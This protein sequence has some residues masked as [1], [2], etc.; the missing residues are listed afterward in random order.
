MTSKKPDLFGSGFLWRRSR[1]L[2][3]SGEE[4][5]SFENGACSWRWQ[6]SATLLPRAEHGNPSKWHQKNPTYSD[7]VFCGGEAG[8]WTLA[9]IHSYYSLSR[10]APS[11]SWVLL[12]CRI[13][14]SS[15]DIISHRFASCQWFYQQ[16]KRQD[17]CILHITPLFS[18]E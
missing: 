10:G 4:K 3:Y 12:H 14:I 13:I 6:G 17:Y 11:A 18:A 9:T 7:R 5:R 16:N 1:N 2:F 15:L 8:I